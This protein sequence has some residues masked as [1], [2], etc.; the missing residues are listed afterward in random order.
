LVESR[1][2]GSDERSLR[3]DAVKPKLL[4]KP[5]TKEQLANLLQIPLRED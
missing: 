5:L 4:A 1:V 3:R 2:G